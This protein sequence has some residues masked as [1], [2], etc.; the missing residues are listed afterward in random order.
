MESKTQQKRPSQLFEQ[1]FA[2]PLPDD[3]QRTRRNL[4]LLS[5]VLIFGIL[6]NVSI[7]AESVGH[8][9]LSVKGLT[10]TK[11]YIAFFLINAY[12]L[13]HFLFSAC[14]HMQSDRLL[15]TGTLKIFRQ[16]YLT[17]EVKDSDFPDPSQYTIAGWW[18]K[19]TSEFQGLQNQAKE[20]VAQ[21]KTTHSKKNDIGVVEALDKINRNL[22][23]IDN[24]QKILYQSAE[25]EKIQQSLR[26]F[27]QSFFSFLTYQRRRFFWI[28]FL[29]PTLLGVVSCGMLA[30]QVV[31]TLTTWS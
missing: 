31:C 5:F 24:N 29:L 14:E 30:L 1:P 7:S 8:F 19:S 16:T 27:D 12:L 23:S 9:S 10:Q 25:A 28:E 22:A 17:E 15:T 20:L 3:I 11:A 13:I 2:K 26:A 4:I 21:I 18:S 6:A